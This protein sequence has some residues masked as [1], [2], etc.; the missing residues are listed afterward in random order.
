MRPP[1][2]TVFETEPDFTP[3][4][5]IRPRVDRVDPRLSAHIHHLV[6]TYPQDSVRVIREWMAEG[7]ARHLR[8]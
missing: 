3:T 6:K 7:P 2:P 8:H 1:S 4:I 5:H